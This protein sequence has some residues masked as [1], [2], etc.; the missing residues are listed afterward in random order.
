MW[1]VIVVVVVIGVVV[2]FVVVVV[3]VVARQGQLCLAGTTLKF[4]V[5]CRKLFRKLHL[6]K[7]DFRSERTLPA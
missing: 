1:P 6:G 4:A 7:V 5:V 3:V 2:V